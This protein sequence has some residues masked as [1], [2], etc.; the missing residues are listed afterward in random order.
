MLTPGSLCSGSAVS[1]TRIRQFPRLIGANLNIS[2]VALATTRLPP[3]SPL[4]STQ[5]CIRQSANVGSCM[6][7]LA[8]CMS[9]NTFG[10]LLKLANPVPRRRMTVV[11]LAS[12]LPFCLI[13]TRAIGWRP[14]RSHHS[15]TP[16]A[17]REIVDWLK[18]YFGRT[19]IS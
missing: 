11:S 18:A 7:A 3:A 8:L 9:L 13:A 4:A 19:V 14:C 15:G 6:G 5:A 12:L 10:T 2:R 16:G 1:P 17:S